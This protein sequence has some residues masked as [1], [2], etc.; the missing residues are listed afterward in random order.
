MPLLQYNDRNMWDAHAG[1]GGSTQAQWRTMIPRLK[2]ADRV[3]A[4]QAKEQGWM[5]PT[6]PSVVKGL[7]THA[8]RVQKRTPGGLLVIG[9]GGS[10]LGARAL[11]QALGAPEDG[12]GSWL[13]FLSNPDPEYIASRLA[14]AEEWLGESSVVVVSKSGKTLETMAIFSLVL[15]RLKTLRGD[16]H[17]EQVYVITDEDENPLHTF[18]KQERYTVIP[19]P[20]NVGGRFSVLTSVGLFPAAVGG[21]DVNGLLKGSKDKTLVQ[22]AKRFAALHVAGMEARGQSVHVL[23]P[24]ADSLSMIGMWYRQLWAESLGKQ[25]KGPTPLAALGTVDQHSQMQLFMEGPNDK[26]VT[27]LSVAKPRIDLRVPATPLQTGLGGKWLSQIMQASLEGTAS[28]LAQQERPNGTILLSSV[29]AQSVGA[30]L[31]WYMIATAYMGALM[32]IDAY[33][34]PGVELGKRETKRALGLS[35]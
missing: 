7:L 23:M 25:G 10:D 21:I 17:R 31:Q 30:L 28:A 33:H 12:H 24:Y 26:I 8:H 1:S 11:W 15:E 27:F 29:T 13:Y 2:E 35:V 18:A 5:T 16:A 20:L 3:I 22:S 4:R 14:H 6:K 32:R 9:I 34:Q 19:H